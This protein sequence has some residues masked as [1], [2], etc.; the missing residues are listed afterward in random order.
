MF[1]CCLC[2]SQE[3]TASGICSTCDKIKKIIACYSPEEVVDT[4]ET[5]YLREKT[6]C[7]AKADVEKK[8]YELRSKKLDKE[9]EKKK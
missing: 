7:D 6:K 3:W 5:V 9:D 4:L 8:T 2:D 1:N